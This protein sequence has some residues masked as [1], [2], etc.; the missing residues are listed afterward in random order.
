MGRKKATPQF[1]AIGRVLVRCAIAS[2]RREEAS[3]AKEK[4]REGGP[5]AV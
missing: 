5:P 4:A 2:A 1:D 3:H